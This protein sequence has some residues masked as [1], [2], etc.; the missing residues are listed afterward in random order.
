MARQYFGTDGIRGRINKAPMTAETALRLAIAAARTFAPEGGREVVIGRDTRRSGEMIEAALVA[1]LTSMGVK[2]VRLGVVPTPAVALITRETGAALGFMVSASHNKY[3]D[4]GLKLFSPEGVKFTDNVEESLE[5]AMG[6]AFGGDYAPP[7]AIAEPTSMAGAGRRYIGRCLET[8]G[9][10]Q[11]FSRLKVVLDCAH[12]AGFETAPEALRRLGAQLTLIG[13]EP[14]GVNINAGVGSTATG[15]L[16]AAVLETGADIGIALDGD[17]D[18]LIVVDE[19]GEE[20]DGDQV[21]ALIASEMHR[22]QRLKG[23]GMV[24]TVMSNM[25]LDEY[26][27][28]SGL[29]LARTKVGDRYV[30]EHMRQHGYNLGGEQ[31]GHIILSDV[32]TTGDGLLAGLQVLAVLAARGGKASSLLRVFEPAPQKLVNIRYTGPNPIESDRVK[33]ALAEADALLGSRGRMVVRKSG[34]EPL[35]RVMAEALDAELMQRALALVADAVKAQ[36]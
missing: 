28:S 24:A 9:K 36:A 13:A 16:K 22:T 27:K 25:G 1:G 23:G 34:T 21:M 5:A 33:A 10:G 11:D 3:E 26:L 30:G 35:I 8:I 15:A 2:P 32:S 19:T 20:A 7:A 12:G 4:N 18:R 29:S 14:D 31:S 6:A 17:A